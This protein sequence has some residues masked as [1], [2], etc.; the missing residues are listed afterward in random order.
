M[1]FYENSFK[2]TSFNWFTGVVEDNEDPAERGRVK[3]RCFG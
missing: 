1:D 3:V 2:S